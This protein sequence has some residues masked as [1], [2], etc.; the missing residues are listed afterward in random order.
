MECK[1]ATTASKE[2]IQREW[3]CKVE[4]C[5]PATKGRIQRKA[6]GCR[7]GCKMEKA[8]WEMT[9]TE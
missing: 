4:N 3:D 1:V 5:S 7:E 6:S 9:Q 2:R 8:E